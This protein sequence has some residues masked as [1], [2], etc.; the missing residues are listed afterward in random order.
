MDPII[1]AGPP[2]SGTSLTTG[3]IALSG[4][5]YGRCVPGT[6]Y[7]P[8]GF[9]EHIV[10]REK[11]CKPLLSRRGLSKLG[12]GDLRT[13]KL[14][15]EPFLRENVFRIIRREGWID[16]PWVYKNSKALLIWQ[17]YQKAFPNAHWVFTDRPLEKVVDSLERAPFM[18]DPGPT[19]RWEDYAQF[20]IDK[21]E[22]LA[23]VVDH[24]WVQPSKFVVG[25]FSDLFPVYEKYGLDFTREAME[26]PDPNIFH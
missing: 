19:G 16:Q 8:K 4:A 13:D 2:R 23:K 9:Y 20:Y 25:D 17:V 15:P 1:V 3:L 22:E 11:I 5:W 21:Q 6:E 26:L 18:K 14:Q 10:L 24:T 12:Q 7:N